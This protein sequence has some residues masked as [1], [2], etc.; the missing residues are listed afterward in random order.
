VSEIAAGDLM[1]VQVSEIAAGDLTV[2][3]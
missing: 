1:L 3:E 2:Y